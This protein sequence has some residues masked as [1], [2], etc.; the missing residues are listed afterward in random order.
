LRTRVRIAGV[1]IGQHGA[2]T[3]PRSQAGRLGARGGRP[4]QGRRKN[5]KALHGPFA[6]P[7]GTHTVEPSLADVRKTKYPLLS[8]RQDHSEKN[9]P[10]RK[11]SK[12]GLFRTIA[13]ASSH[14]PKGWRPGVASQ[15]PQAHGHDSWLGP[16]PRSRSGEHTGGNG[17][18]AG[19]WGRQGSSSRTSGRC[20]QYQSVPIPA[21]QDTLRTPGT[22]P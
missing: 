15:R 11:I 4:S 12:V 3:I 18:R 13:P 17:R 21:S 2:E 10:R 8:F 20:Y 1:G 6:P 19:N 7:V 14:A 9:T 22:S 16:P 5:P